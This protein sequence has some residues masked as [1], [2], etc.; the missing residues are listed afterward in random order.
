MVAGAVITHFWVPS[1][2]QLNGRNRLRAGEPYT[3]EALALG[4]MGRRDHEARGANLR[5]TSSKQRALSFNEYG[6]GAG[7]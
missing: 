1:V 2:Q 6:Y 3:L 4:R 5:K 7:H